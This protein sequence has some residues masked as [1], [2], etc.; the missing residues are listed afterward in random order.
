[1]NVFD[2][3][4]QIVKVFLVILV[5]NRYYFSLIPIHKFYIG[6]GI[7][8]ENF[9]W[10]IISLDGSIRFSRFLATIYNNSF[11]IHSR[12]KIWAV[13]LIGYTGCLGLHPFCPIPNVRVICRVICLSTR[14]CKSIQNQFSL[15]FYL[16][17]FKSYSQKTGLNWS[18]FIKGQKW[19]LCL[20][21]L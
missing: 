12:K 7:N 8:N 13:L 3:S 16:D 10:C 19:G 14:L 6:W 2:N 20:F 5:D 21:W 11:W 15:S 18:F 1:M 17:P 9:V 4:V